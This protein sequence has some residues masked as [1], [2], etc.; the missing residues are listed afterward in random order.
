[1]NQ[2][3][4]PTWS[5]RLWLG[6]LWCLLILL[7]AVWLSTLAH[8]DSVGAAFKSSVEFVV[9]VLLLVVLCFA[10]GVET[11]FADLR[12]KDAEQVL[13]EIR[14]LLSQMKE[15]EEFFLAQREVF[16]VVII[17]GVTL[18]TSFPSV[19][20]FRIGATDRYHAASLFT[21]AFTSLTILWFCQVVPKRLALRNSELF[22][23]RGRFLW[24]IIRVVGKLDLP[25]PSDWIVETLGGVGRRFGN[26]RSLPP[27]R[28]AYYLLSLKR[29]GIAVDRLEEDIEIREGGASVIRRKFLIFIAHGR[30]HDFGRSLQ[31]DSIVQTAGF[32]MCKVFTL[33]QPGDQIEDMAPLLDAVFEGKPHGPEVEEISA[34]RL[35]LQPD[36]SGEGTKKISWKI[37]SQISLPEG[38][39]PKDSEQ[40]SGKAVLLLFE[41][42]AA[43]AAGGFK[44]DGH[45]DFWYSVI[46]GPCRKYSVDVHLAQGLGRKF[47][48]PRGEV[49][50]EG[51]LTTGILEGETTRAFG[52]LERKLTET[53]HLYTAADYLLPG[54]YQLFWK[55]RERR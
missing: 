48:Q 36:S 11:A 54:R 14:Q 39:S 50:F 52:D 24:P 3:P 53:H 17:A 29:Y 38:L 27:S 23:K 40:A 32:G 34:D 1:M 35:D 7:V 31:L 2:P 51:T 8:V 33:P 13:P 21:I 37:Q 10:E 9:V 41:L 6:F 16:T 43:G 15:R 20:L 44:L 46:D 49:T 5:R 12:D 45:D 42:K 55:C 19:Y 47:F 18:L 28:P 25:A 22:L 26:R 30:R 4:G